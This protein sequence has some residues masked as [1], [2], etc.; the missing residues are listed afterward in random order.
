M[1]SIRGGSQLPAICH[2]CGAATERLK[3]IHLVSEAQGTAMGPLM[4]RLI[5]YFIPF[6]G[7]FHRLES[8]GKS[9]EL[10]LKLPTCARCARRVRDVAPRY[11]DF[12]EQRIDLIVHAEFKKALEDG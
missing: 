7:L 1:V 10:Q 4:G 8:H 6:L 2:H 11:I 12:E 3:K 9:V 5:G